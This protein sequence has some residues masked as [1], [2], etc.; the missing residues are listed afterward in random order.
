MIIAECLKCKYNED[1]LT[2]DE[3][4]RI[5]NCTEY[6]TSFPE[7]EGKCPYFKDIERSEEE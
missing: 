6:N 4:Y 7:F 3:H 1:I 2:V 5:C